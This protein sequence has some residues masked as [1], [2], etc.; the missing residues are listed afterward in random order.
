MQSK[1]ERTAAQFA[2][3]ATWGSTTV[4]FSA[5][6]GDLETVAKPPPIDELFSRL[7]RSP[8]IARWTTEKSQRQAVVALEEARQIPSVTVD[9]GVRYFNEDDAAALVFQAAIPLQ[10]FDRNQGSIQEAYARLAKV[11]AEQRSVNVQSRVAFAAA[12]Q[13]LLAAYEQVQTLRDQTLP[14]AEAAFEGTRDGYRNG[15][16]NYLDILDSQRTLFMLRARK[17]DVLLTY[18]LARA[19]IERLTATPLINGGS[20]GE[21]R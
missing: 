3:A 14:A 19:D 4:T 9:A 12:Y 15:L 17:L 8:D 11:N 6:I 5:V 2:L 13:S 16:F 10:V 20:T 18:H 21:L 1:R 7:S